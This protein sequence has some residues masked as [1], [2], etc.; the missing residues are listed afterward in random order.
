MDRACARLLEA[1][2]NN[3]KIRIF[4][5][6]DVDGTTGAAL[7]SH[8]FRECGFKFSAAQPD[9]FKDGYGLNP[10]AVHAAADRGATV[11]VTVDCG[12]SSFEA[13]KVAK[14]RG[15]DLIVLDH[16][17]VDPI[18]GL[19]DAFAIVN[20]QRPDCESGL[21]MLCGCG[22]AFFLCMALRTLMREQGWFEEGKAP[23]LK[24]HLD[25]VVMATAAD[26]VP[27]IGVNHI[28]VRH[29]LQVL[30]RSEKPG[31]RALLRVAGLEGA[32]LSPGHLG[33]TIGPRINAAG[34][35][36]TADAALELLTTFDEARAFELALEIEKRN[37]DRMNTQNA[38]W[39]QAKIEIDQKILEG[40]FP[41]G[42]VVFNPTWH[43]GVVGIV[44]SR[45]AETYRRPAV[46]LALKE[47]G[48][49]AKG[50]VR[51]YAG[52]DVLEALRMSSKFLLGFGGHRHAAGLSLNVDQISNF[53]KAWNEALSQLEAQNEGDTFWIDGYCSEDDFDLKTLE[54]L[55]SLGPFGPGNPE[56]TFVIRASVREQKL[57]KERHLKM[58]LGSRG[59]DA[60][61]FNQSEI[62]D[63]DSEAEWLGVPE[64]NRFRGVSRPSFRIRD[65]KN[66]QTLS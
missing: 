46:V 59:L 10:G 15:V 65:R 44:A 41:H 18:L 56:P 48:S 13:A 35:M 17:Q 58:R 57:L 29:G 62:L 8:F 64:V 23:N 28:L 19:P 54:E 11:L 27:L 9:R 26:M 60:I 63:I 25:L 37:M 32:D 3:E 12:I 22:V 49:A 24:K 21:K 14:D 61:W 53:T 20:P 7:L 45:I 2:K 6:Y 42:V 47:D 16:H 66:I 43:E 51:T 50:S 52:K 39:D 1:R 31:V 5:D 38:I 34:R 33:F 30:R 4:G 40:Y 36:A 55:E